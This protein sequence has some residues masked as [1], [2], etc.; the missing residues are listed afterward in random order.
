MYTLKDTETWFHQFINPARQQTPFGAHCG[1]CRS[2]QSVDYSANC[3]T[4]FKS[5]R[6]PLSS[7]GFSEVD[8]LARMVMDVVEF[9]IEVPSWFTKWPIS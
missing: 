2:S 4:A 1:K 6:L 3:G 5:C 7:R 9:L 8:R